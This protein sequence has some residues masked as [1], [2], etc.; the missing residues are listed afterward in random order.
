VPFWED[1]D[2]PGQGFPACRVQRWHNG[3]E[4]VERLESKRMTPDDG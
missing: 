2:H 3:A 1:P 4:L